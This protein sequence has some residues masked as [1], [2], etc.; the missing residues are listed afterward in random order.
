MEVLSLV[1]SAA[2]CTNLPVWAC[3]A[4]AK[5][6]LDARLL[7]AVCMVESSGNPKAIAVMDGKS[8]SYGLCQIKLR[9]AKYVG[10]KG[11]AQELMSADINALYAARYISY[12]LK[13]QKN[14]NKA[15]SAYNAGRPINS[16]KKYV[17]KV[18]SNYSALVAQ[19][20]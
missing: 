5:T 15:I 9:T 10:F 2:A 11:S 8:D 16:N 14:V 6:G 12:H 18:L 1:I 13:R 17:N 20:E 19:G 7:V 4:Q 3:D